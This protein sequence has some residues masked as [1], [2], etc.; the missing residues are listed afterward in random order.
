MTYGDQ[1][2]SEL[3]ESVMRVSGN[4]CE[5]MN[6]DLVSRHPNWCHL[7]GHMHVHW[8]SSSSWLFVCLFKLG[9]QVNDQAMA[10]DWLLYP[11][12]TATCARPCHQS[13]VPVQ[14]VQVFLPQVEGHSI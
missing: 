12:T 1:I 6:Q 3:C 11:M 7:G 4:G 10:M 8:S 2:Q 13:N 9:G 14:P 5:N